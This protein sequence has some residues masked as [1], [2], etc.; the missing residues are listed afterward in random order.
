MIERM[1]ERIIIQKNTAV[2]DRYGNRKAVWT[3]Y[4]TC[5]S[6]ASTYQY[7]REKEAV[8]TEQEQ[9][10]IFEARYCSELKNLDST[11]YRILFHGE[12]YDIQSVDMMNYQRKTLRIRTQKEAR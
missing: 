9:T 7:D 6:Y 3:D 5:W 4:F 8:I 10:V 11:H 2:A 1:N 12:T